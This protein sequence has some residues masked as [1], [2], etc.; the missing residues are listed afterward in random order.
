MSLRCSKDRAEGNKDDMCMS[1][2]H[3]RT[4]ASSAREQT[5]LSQQPCRG[6]LKPNKVLFCCSC[7]TMNVRADNVEHVNPESLAHIKS[8]LLVNYQ[9]PI[10]LTTYSCS[11]HHDVNHCHS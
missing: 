2:C 10:V 1:E 4:W 3:R 8:C 9:L 7:K 11:R 6:V 5:P